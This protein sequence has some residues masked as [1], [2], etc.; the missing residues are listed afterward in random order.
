M[1][2]NFLALIFIQKLLALNAAYFPK[3][4][5]NTGCHFN[6]VLVMA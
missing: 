3:I 4:D 1:N 6:L 5:T 2:A